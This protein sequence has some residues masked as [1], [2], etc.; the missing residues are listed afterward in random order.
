MASPRPSRRPRLPTLG[1]AIEMALATLRR[2]PLVLACGVLAATAAILMSEDIGP[3]WLR[4]RLLAV[5]T[6]GLP[7]F[8]AAKLLGERLPSAVARAGATLA[9]VAL[10][11]AVHVS[12][13]GW[14]E[15]VRVARYVELS[16]AFHLLVA[17]LPFV[18]RDRPTAFWQ[19]NRTLFERFLVAGISSATLF[20]GL[21]L[22]LAAVNKLFGVD[23]PRGA[24][25]RVWV[26][27][28]FV[29][30]TWFFLGGVPRDLEALDGRREYPTVLRVFAQYTLVPLV[31]VYLVILTLY[32]GKVVVSWDWPSGWIGYLVS[33]VAGAGILTLLLVHPLAEREEQ[34]WVTTFAR[35]FWLGVLPA[36][37][38]AV[39]GDLPAPA[40]VRLHRAALFP[41]RPVR[42]AGRDRGVLRRDALPEA[43]ASSRP[44]CACCHW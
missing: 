18:G 33:G 13:D 10:L 20:L 39:A 5:A 21:A 9:A 36:V 3:A 37:G 44:R 24:Y 26:L 41:A 38:D 22:A 28:A 43:S 11:V 8:T 31:T 23:L 40:A 32:F 2:F 14:L 15:P 34:R 27:C 25:V 6:L 17:F 19:Y 29:F 4:D 30:N 35:W 7:L 1:A 12:W 16:L 42:V